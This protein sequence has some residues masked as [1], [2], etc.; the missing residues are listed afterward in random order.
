MS[1][2]IPA[3]NDSGVQA[4]IKGLYE[5]IKMARPE[6]RPALEQEI[7]QRRKLIRFSRQLEGKPCSESGGRKAHPI[8]LALCEAVVKGVGWRP[9]LMAHYR[10]IRQRVPGYAEQTR[11]IDS[12]KRH[13]R[14]YKKKFAP[15][16]DSR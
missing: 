16:S 4:L 8:T 2:F 7:R 9:A 12:A 5:L 10:S 11:Q 3:A 15:R 6:R 1:G 14:R 13:M